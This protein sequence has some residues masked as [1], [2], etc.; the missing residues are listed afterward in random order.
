MDGMVTSKQL[1]DA[2]GVRGVNTLRQWT[3]VG[4]LPEPT[5]RKHPSGQGMISYFPEW[6]LRRCEQIQELR[7][8]GKTRSQIVDMIL[9]EKSRCDSQLELQ[10]RRDHKFMKAMASS[11]W[12]AAAAE[13]S[14]QVIEQVL[15]NL[16]SNINDLERP[17]TFIAISAIRCCIGLMQKGINPVLVLDGD[18]VYVTGDIAVPHLLRR[19]YETNDMI[20]IV[21]MAKVV[22]G[23][24][25]GSLASMR[26]QR[27]WPNF[28]ADR[29][30]GKSAVTVSVR[31]ADDGT[32]EI[33][34]LPPG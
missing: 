28:T 7:A 27:L 30:K 5:L 2:A 34:Y 14:T 22:A 25:P 32:A 33:Q 19:R 8:L 31:F 18:E 3:K 15:A 12:R 29:G 9:T 17:D 21:P 10:A 26:D 20:T 23:I 16:H 6:T 24:A 13:L 1:Q 4:L 11:E